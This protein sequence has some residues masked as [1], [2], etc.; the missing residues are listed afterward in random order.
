MHDEVAHYNFGCGPAGYALEI[1]MTGRSQTKG[2]KHSGRPELIKTV[3]TKPA[4]RKGKGAP[5]AKTAPGSA[6]IGKQE[7]SRVNK[8]AAGAIDDIFGGAPSGSAPRKQPLKQFQ[9]AVSSESGKS[10]KSSAGHKSADTEGK[11]I[12]AAGSKDDLFASGPTKKRRCD[13]EGLPIFSVDELEIGKGKDTA[14]CP[15]DCDCCF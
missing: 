6:P 12:R 7:A 14:D 9:P 4:K 15:F 3:E 8:A 1:G 11:H 13:A 5:A 2:S 10:G